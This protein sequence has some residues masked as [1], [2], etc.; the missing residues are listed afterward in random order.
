MRR[1][2]YQK[3]SLRLADRKKGKVWEFLWREV[4]LDGSIRRKHIVIGTLDDFPTES[5]A[6]TAVDAI[7]LE[8]NQ[9]TPQQLLKNI[10]FETLINHYRQHELPDI[11]NKTKPAPD[12]ED[13]DRKSYST[14]VT[15]EGYLKKWILP[16]WRAC[17][18]TD[19]KAVEVE[20]WLKTLCFPKTGIPLARGSRAKIRNIMSALYSHA[21]R[22]EWAEKNPITSVRQ[23]AKRQKAPDILTPEEIMAFLAELPDPLRTMIELDAFTGLRRGELIGLRWMDVDFENL[24]LHVRR[25]LVAMV[26]GAPKTEAS[27]KDVPLDA[28]TAESLWAWKQRSP[29]G[30]QTDWVFASPHMKGRQPYWPGTLWRYYG[31]PA[32][33]RAGVT[34]Q[35]SF[36]TFRHTFGTLLNANGENSKVVQELLRHASLKVTTDVYMQAVGPQKRE[37]QSNLVKL[38]R[39]GA[40]S[41]VKPG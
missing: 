30:A 15:Y 19:I 33:K 38:V 5:A 2:S 10:S 27:L 18:L 13:E 14:Q 1:T 25:S 3:G 31:K 41:K 26:E 6:Q 12:A 11:F 29:H 21:I 34:K 4:Q 9:Q 8:I 20:K 35:V 40:T 23:S 17:R 28:L 36:H 37:A 32:L 16:R 22:W 7:R 24:I 39:K